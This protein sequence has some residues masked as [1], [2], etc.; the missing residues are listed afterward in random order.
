MISSFGHTD[1][2]PSAGSKAV[3]LSTQW[4]SQS[5]IVAVHAGDG[6][7]RPLSPVGG[8]QQ[9]SFS[10]LAIS[11]DEV[12]ATQVRRTLQPLLFSP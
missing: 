10:L 12:F 11:G 5:A 3:L 1:P 7:V 4:R 2:S 9:T 6:R 8:P